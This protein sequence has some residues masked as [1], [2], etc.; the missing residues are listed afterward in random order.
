MEKNRSLAIFA[1]LLTAL[2]GS[3]WFFTGSLAPPPGDA[4]LWFYGGLFALLVAKFITEYRFTKPND[5]VVNC[6]TAFVAISTL[7]APPHA[8]WWE[9]LRWSAFGCAAIALLV[10]WDRRRT[11]AEESGLIRGSIYRIVTRVGSAEVLFSL[12]FVLALLSYLDTASDAARV[13]VVF[14]GATLLAANLRLGTTASAFATRKKYRGRELLG[15]AHSFLS[16]SIVYCTRLTDKSLASH[17]LVGFAQ[18]MRSDPICYGLIID[19]RASTGETL[20]SVALL[21]TTVGQACVN[22]TSLLLRL[23]E[24]DSEHAKR[25]LAQGHPD[26]LKKVI[27]T[28]SAGTNISQVKFELFGSP[29]IRAGSLLG[30]GTGDKPVFY[31]VFGGL[32]A[33]EA[34][35]RQST[36]AFIEGEAEQVGY[37]DTGRGGFETH[38]W[39]VPERSLVRLIDEGFAPPQYALKPAEV[40][41]GSIPNSNYAVNIDL[42]DAVLYHT[43]ILGVT[44]SGKSF[45]TYGLVENCAQRGIKVICVDPTGDYQRYIPNAVIVDSTQTIKAFL[46]SPDHRIAIWETGAHAQHAIEQAKSIANISLSWCKSV[47]TDEDVLHP[48]PKLLVVFEEAHLLVPEWN[49]N[50][51]KNLQDTVSTTSQIVLQARKYGLGFLVISQRTANVVKSVLN[52][53]NTVVSFQAF[54]ETGF[55]FLR[56]YMGSYHVRS[57]PNLKPRHGILVGKASLSRRPLMV[58]FND[59]MRALVD[60]PAPTMPLPPADDPAAPGDQAPTASP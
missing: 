10:A 34:T 15:T 21:E 4:S 12:V 22:D 29:T 38:D 33:E 11:S 49:F 23:N 59:Q 16:P 13:F 58:R 47:R 8:A 60:Q 14:W 48:K 24:N 52:Q 36:R 32:I 55:E 7:N 26:D 31:Q 35:L 28:V 51:Q 40:R 53:C 9:L 56:N 27:G 45:L 20:V 1:I 46:Q 18:S 25:T 30:V 5:A 44:G 17:E 54:D 37:W 57:L 42:E 3:L 43:S 2:C 39:V 50:P 41:V 19:E 6:V